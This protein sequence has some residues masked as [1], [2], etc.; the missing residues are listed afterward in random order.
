MGGV[1]RHNIRRLQEAKSVFS[2]TERECLEFT[3]IL[4]L[5]KVTLGTLD[6]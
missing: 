1:Q 5:L 6:P 4:R 3:C 2:R